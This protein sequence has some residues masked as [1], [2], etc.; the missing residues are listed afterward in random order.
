MENASSLIE[1]ENIQIRLR[2]ILIKFDTQQLN[3]GDRYPSGDWLSSVDIAEEVVMSLTSLW[4]LSDIDFTKYVEFSMNAQNNR[5]LP[6]YS[7]NS[8]PCTLNL[9]NGNRHSFA[10]SGDTRQYHLDE[11]GRDFIKTISFW[12]EKFP[13]HC[14]SNYFNPI[15]LL[16]AEN[17]SIKMSSDSWKR[18]LELEPRFLEIQR[19]IG[20]NTNPSIPNFELYRDSYR[21]RE[22]LESL[23]ESTNELE[24]WS[25]KFATVDFNNYM[26]QRFSWLSERTNIESDTP[27][28]TVTTIRNLRVSDIDEIANARMNLENNVTVRIQKLQYGVAAINARI[29]YTESQQSKLKIYI[30]DIDIVPGSTT[31]FEIDKAI[32][33][34]NSII[35][36]LKLIKQS[37]LKEISTRIKSDV[38]DFDGSLDLSTGKITCELT[39][40]YIDFCIKNLEDEYKKSVCALVASHNIIKIKL[41]ELT[42]NYNN[43]VALHAMDEGSPVVLD[44]NFE[45]EARKIQN[46][47]ISLEY[48]LAEIENSN[49]LKTKNGIAIAYQNNYCTYD[50]W[51]QNSRQGGLLEEKIP[52]ELIRLPYDTHFGFT[53]KLTLACSVIA[54]KSDLKKVM[55]G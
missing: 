43:L 30:D 44:V 1:Q 35:N 26:L 54:N 37:M 49:M 3:S 45:N 40:L 15:L 13:E 52:D 19:L 55:G 8:T 27:I 23:F 9:F 21:Y 47:I 14:K 53:R 32:V 20:R 6:K 25:K 10:Y 18:L 2:E 34:D 4:E 50:N 51:I 38:N 42:V 22:T 11:L 36:D 46:E 16:L 48:K 39:D 5:A 7:G 41:N 33:K 17:S 12:A 24:I 29:L 28:I 31:K